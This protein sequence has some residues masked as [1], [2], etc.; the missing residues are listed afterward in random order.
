MSEYHGIEGGKL[1][2]P[3]CGS[4]SVTVTHIQRFYANSGDH[5]CHTIK[6]RDP[7]SGADCLSCGWVGRRD[8]L[9][10]KD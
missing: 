2:C 7:D 9:V 6:V 1:T 8:Q 10:A 5:Y 4:E 3:E